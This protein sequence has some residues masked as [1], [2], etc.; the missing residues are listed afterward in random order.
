VLVLINKFVVT[1]TGE[2]F[3][4]VFVETA[5]FMRRQPGF[6]RYRLIRSEQDSSVYINIAEWTDKAALMAVADR[7]EM[8]DHL[9]QIK[10]VAIPEPQFF[11][12]V[13]EAGPANAA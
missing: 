5:E 6:L 13:A 4:K 11:A 9:A 3:E 2:E 1:T 7:P 10:A 8:S 12:P